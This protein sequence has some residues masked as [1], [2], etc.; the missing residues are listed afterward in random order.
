M[1]YPTDPKSVRVRD[2]VIAV[3]KDIV[4][5]D[6]FF[7]TPGAVYENRTTWKEVESY[8]AYIVWFG[9]GGEW[10]EYQGLQAAE[11]FTLVVHGEFKDADDAPASV[12]KGIRD[13]RKALMDDMATG[14]E[15]SLAE[16]VDHLTLGATSTDN[17]TG[18]MIGVGYFDQEFLVTISGKIEDL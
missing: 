9:S 12:R 1:S 13:V 18:T 7:F 10:K 5:G 17:G 4:E 14:G 11:T 15:D 16:L 8:P 3:L 2:R 6:D